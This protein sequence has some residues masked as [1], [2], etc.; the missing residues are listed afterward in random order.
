MRVPVSGNNF[1]EG[2]E[3]IRPLGR[4]LHNFN[5]VPQNCNF[6]FKLVWKHWKL[7]WLH[8]RRVAPTPTIPQWQQVLPEE[9][10]G[11]VDVLGDDVTFV[12]STQ[13][14]NM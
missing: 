1:V 5:F 4:M 7:A 12:S 6:F 10:D 8:T 3:V 2:Y 13:K 9:L 14:K 11:N